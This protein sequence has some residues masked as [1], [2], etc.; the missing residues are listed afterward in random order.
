MSK[1]DSPSK[2]SD[3]VLTKLDLVVG[4][5]LERSVLERIAFVGV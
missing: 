3:L 4:P 1:R 2:D 5:D